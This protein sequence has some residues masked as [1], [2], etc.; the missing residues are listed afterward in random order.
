MRT[1]IA[2]AAVITAASTAILIGCGNSA[3][4]H[5]AQVKACTAA[6]TALIKHNYANVPEEPAACKG[7]PLNEVEE[8]TTKVVANQFPGAS[9]SPTLSSSP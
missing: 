1:T 2:A 6:M 8:I 9:V 7:L 3:A 5:A 4:D